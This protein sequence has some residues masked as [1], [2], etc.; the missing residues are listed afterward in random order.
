MQLD[1]STTLVGIP[2]DLGRLLSTYLVAE[3]VNSMQLACK[4]TKLYTE[5][6]LH[7]LFLDLPSRG[8]IIR[9]ILSH[10][11]CVHEIDMI[12]YVPNHS[13]CNVNAKKNDTPCFVRLVGQ[14][15]TYTYNVQVC[16]ITASSE[17]L[18]AT[19]FDLR[20]NPRNVLKHSIPLGSIV[21]PETML[22]V[23]L[24]RGQCHQQ[25][26]TIVGRFR[27]RFVEQIIAPFI[28]NM[29]LVYERMNL[30]NSEV[31]VNDLLIPCN[32]KERRKAYWIARW[33]CD[34][35]M[36]TGSPHENNEE[37]STIIHNWN[38]THQQ[39]PIHTIEILPDHA[40]IISW[41]CLQ[42]KK[43][44]SVRIQIH[45]HEEIVAVLE[46]IGKNTIVYRAY[47]LIS[48]KIVMVPVPESCLWENIMKTRRFPGI[49]DY[50]TFA[51]VVSE[52]T[53]RVSDIYTYIKGTF[54]YVNRLSAISWDHIT[55]GSSSRVGFS[56]KPIDL[57]RL[58]LLVYFWME[59]GTNEKRDTLLRGRLPVTN[60]ECYT[61]FRLLREVL[62][63]YEPEMDDRHIGQCSTCDYYGG[64]SDDG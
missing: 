41:L 13:V 20:I 33:V 42:M 35:K 10:L 19:L 12:W 62:Q 6:R 21:N 8:E 27:D 26:S 50:S 59:L 37:I 36:N 61:I 29:P 14:N 7:N 9:W 22:K 40:T 53:H 2:L 11:E 46:I 32:E 15:I 64:D 56:Y 48:N 39:E 25:A 60:E 28:T 38:M 16:Y 44:R 3:D 45:T 4:R 17:L 30:Y 54:S 58:M 52:T 63:I 5:E 24:Y 18:H 23:M 47:A 34:L 55:S 57:H 43:G 51:V 1:I 31:E 49:V